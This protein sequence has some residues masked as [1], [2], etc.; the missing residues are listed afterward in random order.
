MNIIKLFKIARLKVDKQLLNI[1][2]NAV[3]FLLDDN[4]YVVSICVYVKIFG[5][6]HYKINN[7]RSTLNELILIIIELRNVH[8]KKENKVYLKR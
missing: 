3:A 7:T 1:F 5:I 6:L 2:N 8:E 4:N